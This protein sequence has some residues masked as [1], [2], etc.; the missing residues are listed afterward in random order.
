MYLLTT[1]GPTVCH[2]LSS[3]KR[4]LFC[5]FVCRGTLSYYSVGAFSISISYG[6][7]LVVLVQLC[8]FEWYVIPAGHFPQ[9]SPSR[10]LKNRFSPLLTT[11]LSP[12]TS[13]PWPHHVL[14]WLDTCWWN[15]GL[16]CA[17]LLC[18]SKICLLL[19]CLPWLVCTVCR[20][21]LTISWFPFS[22][23]LTIFRAGPCLM[24]GFTFSSAHPSSCYHLLPYHSII[25]AAEFILFQS[26][27]ALLGLPFILPLMAQ[28]D[29][30]FLCYITSGLL[31][32]ICFPLGVPGPFA[33]LRFH[34]PFS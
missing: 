24:V 32:P 29:H 20:P 27:W 23:W 2:F 3:D 12:L 34:R 26:S 9:K 6:M 19:M 17:S 28:Q 15:L 21:F 25:P 18:M 8:P 16:T 22:L 30:W 10:N 14:Y 33:F 11:K 5:L 4:K 1:T 13:D 7:H 31:C